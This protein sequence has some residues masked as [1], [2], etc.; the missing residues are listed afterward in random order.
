V[1]ERHDEAGR[2]AV[3]T[4][5]IEAG[6]RPVRAKTS[7]ADGKIRRERGA[8]HARDGHDRSASMPPKAQAKGPIVRGPGELLVCQ[9]CSRL[10]ST[11][12]EPRRV[13]IRK[14]HAARH[15]A[16]HRMGRIKRP[17]EKA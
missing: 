9:P 4:G 15:L 8:K 5:P 6:R 10:F 12:E 3:A 2:A 7:G 11:P 1:D 16:D 14:R 13:G 17:T